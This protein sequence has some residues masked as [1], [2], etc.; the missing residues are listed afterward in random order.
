MEFAQNILFSGAG[1]TKNFGGL[2]AKEM[3]S[4]IF[5][6]SDVQ[7]Q[8]RLKELILD[9]FDYESIYHKIINGDFT[10]EEK[11]SINAVIYHAYQVLDE[12]CR[13]WTFRNDAPHPVNIYGVNKF[14]ELFSGDRN[15]SGFFFT[16]NQDLFIERHFNSLNTAFIH[17]GVPK[18]PNAHKTTIRLPI[19]K[20]DFIRIPTLDELKGS[21]VNPL[22]RNAIHYVK[23]HGSFGWKS[24]KGTDS[25]V[26]GKEKEKRVTDEPLLSWYFELLKNALSK[27]N[28]KLMLIGY[29]FRDRHINEVIAN[30]VKNNGLKVY[31]ISPSEQSEFITNL[32]SEEYGEIILGGLSGYYPYTLLDIFPSDQSDSHAW[33]EILDSY[34]NLKFIS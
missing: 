25:Y 10:D 9:D 19:E 8:P 26:I 12:I 2:L 22:S 21:T 15:E 33:R 34:F 17:P 14:I 1:F 20:E 3:W 27:S 29:G 7:S 4:K 32:K 31:I 6:H 30:S 16:L 11:S 23:L 18:I 28:R 24:A 13:Q 5:N